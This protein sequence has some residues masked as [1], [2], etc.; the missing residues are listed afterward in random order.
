[1]SVS[2]EALRNFL[3]SIRNTAT[4]KVLELQNTN[5][6]VLT[7]ITEHLPPSLPKTISGQIWAIWVALDAPSGGL[8]HLLGALK[9]TE[10]CVLIHAYFSDR[11]SYIIGFPSTR[12]QR[13]GVQGVASESKNALIQKPPE[14]RSPRQHNEPIYQVHDSSQWSD[15][16][17]KT[18]GKKGCT[19]TIKDNLHSSWEAQQHLRPKDR[20]FFSM[21]RSSSISRMILVLATSCLACWECEEARGF[22]LPRV[23]QWVFLEAGVANFRNLA[24]F[25]SKKRKKIVICRFFFRHFSSE[26]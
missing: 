3:N 2:T 8:Q 26:N 18:E 24:N 5:C 12:H 11:R 13:D 21:T 4:S 25:S 10:G 20:G 23:P 14:H 15:S 1:M 6:H 19:T 17:M 9:A 22:F 16:K 7:A